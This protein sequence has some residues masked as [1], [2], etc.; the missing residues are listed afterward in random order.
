M[1]PAHG[2]EGREQPGP[3]MGSYLSVDC[4]SMLRLPESIC[5]STPQDPAA[6]QPSHMLLNQPGIAGF[7]FQEAVS[8]RL[9]G[10]CICV[11]IGLCQK[12]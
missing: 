1:E 3:G 11:C 7:L 8:Q 10:R 4:I 9:G 2:A 5:G 12:Q 6:V